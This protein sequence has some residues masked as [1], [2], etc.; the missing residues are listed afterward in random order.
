M[1][2]EPDKKK[3]ENSITCIL[4]AYIKIIHV[5]YKTEWV[6]FTSMYKKLNK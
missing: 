5:F 1:D 2:H 4:S 3:N 6:N